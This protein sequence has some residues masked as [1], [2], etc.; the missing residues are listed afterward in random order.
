MAMIRKYFFKKA[1]A[2]YP[3]RIR[4]YDPVSSMT[5]EETITL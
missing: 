5:G 2:I 1:T 3:G 4:S